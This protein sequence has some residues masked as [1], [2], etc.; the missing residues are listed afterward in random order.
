MPTPR[1]PAHGV[2]SWE[3]VPPSAGFAEHLLHSLAAQGR[4]PRPAQPQ[5]LGLVAEQG[6]KA[7]QV[8]TA[9]WLLWSWQAGQLCARGPGGSRSRVLF[10]V[11]LVCTAA[12]SQ[13]FCTPWAAIRP[14]PTPVLLSW[15]HRGLRKQLSVCSTSSGSLGPGQKKGLRGPV[16]S[17][18]PGPEF[19]RLRLMRR[20]GGH[21]HPA[22]IPSPADLAAGGRK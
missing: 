20:E 2:F 4:H 14:P 6:H 22:P 16:R 18:I 10:P 15:L 13:A 1:A 5:S 17:P 3:T 8:L 19:T 7:A 21:P 9:A 12:S 11:H